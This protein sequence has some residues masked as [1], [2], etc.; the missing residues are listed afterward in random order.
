[1]RE[2]IS[3]ATKDLRLL[4][5]N[6]GRIFFTFIWPVIVTV[7]FGFAF[8]GGPEGEQG[9]PKVAIVDEDN[10]DGSRAFAKKLENSFETTAMTR[11]EAENSVRRGERTAYIA[12]APGFGVAADR[13]F[14]GQPKQVEVGVD[15]ARRAEA[16]MIEGL[17]M[18]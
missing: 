13:M 6:K 18:K 16:G 17:L 15:P 14:Y 2:I 3:L 8:G 9:K 5:R 1:M 12:M 11:A 7:L 4:L 10:S